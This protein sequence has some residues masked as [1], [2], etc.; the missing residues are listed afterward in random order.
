M[1][2]EIHTQTSPVFN[3][4]DLNFQV[5]YLDPCITNFGESGFLFE[6][7]IRGLSSRWF[8]NH[9][10]LSQV[11]A[12]YWKPKTVVT[13][14][15]ISSLIRICPNTNM[16]TRILNRVRTFFSQNFESASFWGIMTLGRAI[17][18]SLLYTI[19][20]KCRIGSLNF[21]TNLINERLPSICW[22]SFCLSH[23]SLQNCQLVLQQLLPGQGFL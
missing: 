14:I 12:R 8:P 22:G 10:Y 20:L 19:F 7:P 1:P 3:F 2:F 18:R 4:S 6:V 16:L 23:K 9:W 5:F 17:R 11:E 13:R 15:L 21:L